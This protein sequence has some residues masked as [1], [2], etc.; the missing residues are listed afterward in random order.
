MPAVHAQY[1]TRSFLLVV[2]LAAP[3][4]SA[5]DAR[6]V[7]GDANGDGPV[8]LADAISILGYLFA[9]ESPP[10]CI[11]AADANDDGR[12]DV[13]DVVQMLRHLFGAGVVLPPPAGACGDDTTVDSLGC[14]AYPRCAL[15]PH[16]VLA[17]W[18]EEHPEV[19]YRLLWWVPGQ[20][21]IPFHIW[22]DELKNEFFARY[23]AA[24]RGEA[25]LLPAAP[26]NLLPHEDQGSL[27]TVLSW[28]DAQALYL[29]LV[30]TSLVVEFKHLVPWSFA[31]YTIAE[32]EMLF[33]GLKLFNRNPLCVPGFTPFTNY[34]P[35][36][37]SCTDVG[38]ELT[39]VWN[40]PAPGDMALRFLTDEVGIGESRVDTIANLIEWSRRSMTH[41]GGNY[42][43]D[44]VD[45][46][47]GY[48]GAVP[49]ARVMEGTDPVG[50]HPQSA[51]WGYPPGTGYDALPSHWTAGCHGTVQFF[52]EVLRVINVPVNYETAGGHAMP[53]F[54]GD[55][56]YLSHG[57]DPYS[58]MAKADYPASLLLIDE[59]TH[60]A[61]FDD[62]AVAAAN[63]GR[64][65]KVLAVTYLPP[66][67]LAYRCD[68]LAAGL[69]LE[70]GSVYQFLRAAYTMEELDALDFWD[71]LDAAIIEAGGCR[72]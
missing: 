33:S 20:G 45:Y 59:A 42:R 46:Y 5:G 49:T 8:D 56:V 9:D 43:T 72:P 52:R 10:P 54:M 65:V 62:P 21:W 35:V 1:L 6:F 44:V 41:F 23:D 48:R 17:A 58:S 61:W 19:R 55:D 12:F 38:L 37:A 70:E 28:R 31:D 51:D 2:A 67:L 22:S 26:P 63:I 29:S 4:V 39:S 14:E 47:W 50:F 25:S 30:A 15:T 68:D 71:R 36:P 64:Q 53:H 16:E 57:D 3:A 7:R 27:T 69:S 18:L 60:E 32:M 34:D 13:S 66:A 11:D 24:W 40:M